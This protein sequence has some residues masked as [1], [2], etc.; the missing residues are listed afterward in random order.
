MYNPRNTIRTNVKGPTHSVT[1]ETWNGRTPVWTSTTDRSISDVI[2][3]II[4]VVVVVVVVVVIKI[5]VAN[6]V[7]CILQ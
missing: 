5:T 1:T 4:I 6:V 2:V 3:A 7:F